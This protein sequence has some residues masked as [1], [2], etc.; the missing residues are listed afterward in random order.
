L[1][2]VRQPDPGLGHIEQH[3]L[4]AGVARFVG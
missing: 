4:G 3:G 2:L 1:R